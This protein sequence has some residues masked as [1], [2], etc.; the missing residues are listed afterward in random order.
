MAHQTITDELAGK[1]RGMADELER[2]AAD[3]DKLRR[4]R[5]RKW[6]Q[7]DVIEDVL[8]LSP[9]PLDRHQIIQEM[10][11]CG[12]GFQRIN[13]DPGRSVRVNLCNLERAGRVAKVTHPGPYGESVVWRAADRGDGS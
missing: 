8:R 10:R 3:L 1:L 9:T 2:A 7:P 6:N 13:T 5:Y 11:R 4:E 12:Y